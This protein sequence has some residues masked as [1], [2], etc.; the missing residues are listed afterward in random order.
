[1]WHVQRDWERVVCF[2]LVQIEQANLAIPLL[3]HPDYW[4]LTDEE[5]EECPEFANLENRAVRFRREDIATR[6]RVYPEVN[7][8]EA[9][10]VLWEFLWKYE[11]DGLVLNDQYKC[12][13]SWY[14][15]TTFPGQAFPLEMLTLVWTDKT[16]HLQVICENTQLRKKFNDMVSLLFA[17]Y[18]EKIASEG[19][20]EIAIKDIED[21][22]LFQSILDRIPVTPNNPLW[23]NAKLKIEAGNRVDIKSEQV[24]APEDAQGSASSGAMPKSRPRTIPKLVKPEAK[25]EFKTKREPDVRAEEMPSLLELLDRNDKTY[26]TLKEELKEEIGKISSCGGTEGRRSG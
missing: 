12:R 19:N 16:R 18:K 7:A 24:V 5:D 20:K 26:R 13:V 9:R 15:C 23:S 2:L 8:A 14:A 4:S 3:H 22:F 17:G 11:T 10:Q 25:D 6:G 1:M 21:P